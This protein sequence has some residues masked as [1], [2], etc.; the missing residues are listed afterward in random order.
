MKN[1]RLYIAWVLCLFSLQMY[2]NTAKSLPH[3][4]PPKTEVGQV[5]SPEIGKIARPIQVTMPAQRTTAISIGVPLHL[6]SSSAIRSQSLRF[7]SGGSVFSSSSG[8]GAFSSALVMRARV[9]TRTSFSSNAYVSADDYLA[10]AVI[11]RKE[12]S[13]TPPLPGQEGSELPPPITPLTTTWGDLLLL[14]L[15]VIGY[16]MSKG[17][18]VRKE[19]LSH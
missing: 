16:G 2:A 15:L 1:I 7:S 6:T 13:T 9:N 5:V 12:N 11:K 19:S 8:G 14:V 4:A 17:S 18:K 3:I 10:S